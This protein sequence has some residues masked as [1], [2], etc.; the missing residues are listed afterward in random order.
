MYLHQELTDK[1]IRCF[2]NVYNGLGYEFLEKVYE[3]ALLIELRNSGLIAENQFP[4][5]V[6]YQESE[7]GSYYADI[8][9]ENKV[10]LELKAGDM[11]QAIINHELQ[12]TNY[13]K[14][15]NYEVGLLLLFGIKPQVKRKIFSND[16][17]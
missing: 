12:L 5:K 8:L 13:L 11:E 17:K 3:N 14:A 15:T 2:Y 4:I 1:I 6:Y 9:V 16:I 10:I 7:V